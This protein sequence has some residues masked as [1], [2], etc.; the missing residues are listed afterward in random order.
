[1]SCSEPPPWWLIAVLAFGAWRLLGSSA[2]RPSHSAARSSSPL[3][4]VSRSSPRSL[5][6]GELVAYAAGNAARMR[7]FLRPVG[8]GRTLPLTDDSTAVEA[9]PRWSPD[10][11]SVLFLARGGVSIAPALGGASRPVV[12]ASAIASVSTATWSPD[13][14]EIAFVRAESLLVAPV[15]GGPARL[16]ATT[17]D[18][19]SCAWSPAKKWIACVVL[20]SESVLPGTHV[21]QSRPERHPAVSGRRRRSRPPG[22]ATGVQPESRVDARRS[23]AALHLQSRRP[24]RCVRPV[25]LVVRTVTGRAGPAYH[26]ARRDFHVAVGG[27]PAAGVRGV[28]GTRQHLVAAHPFAA[29]PSRPTARHHSRV[30]AR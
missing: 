29:P 14:R 22:R 7:I 3:I 6:T 23:S 30:E 5:Q 19:H 27:W 10:G 21:R 16:L 12:P 11:N 1:M 9:Q 24:A 15:E 4:R 8:G 18:L 26:R 20:N 17:F 13:G 25:T 2:R 28:F